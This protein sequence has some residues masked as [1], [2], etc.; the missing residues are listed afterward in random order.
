VSIP[1][2]VVTCTVSTLPSTTG[3]VVSST[4]TVTPTRNLVWAAT[5]QRLASMCTVTAGPGWLVLPACD[6]TGFITPDT[7]VSVTGWAYLL[8]V[9]WTENDGTQHSESGQITCLTSQ[10]VEYLVDVAGVLQTSTTGIT[11]PAVALAVMTAAQYSALSPPDPNT[12]YFT[13]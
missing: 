12:L 8:T 4:A 13:Y 5:G 1:G 9:E 11:G 2:G 3:A 10:A 6:Q 7:H